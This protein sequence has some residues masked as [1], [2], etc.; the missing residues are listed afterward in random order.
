M[1]IQNVDVTADGA[2]TVTLTNGTVLHLGN[3]KGADGLGITK[4]EINTSGE[5]VLTYSNGDVKNLG[6]VSGE[7][8]K[9]GVNGADGLGIKSR[10]V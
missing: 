8:G 6:Q 7:N 9:D 10:C 1:G 2:L 4:A 3:I 5:L